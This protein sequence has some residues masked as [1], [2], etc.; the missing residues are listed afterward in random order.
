MPAWLMQR[1]TYQGERTVPAKRDADGQNR[2]R[3]QHLSNNGGI[4]VVTMRRDTVTQMTRLIG[5]AAGTKNPERSQT[6]GVGLTRPCK[7]IR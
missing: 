6:L 5:G 3:G 1:E 7:R 4:G 2:E